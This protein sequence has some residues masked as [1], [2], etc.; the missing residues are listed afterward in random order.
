MS[1]SRSDL[2]D[3]AGLYGK[4]QAALDWREKLARLLAYKAVDIPLTDD[5]MNFHQQTRNG[6]GWK[7]LAVIGGLGLGYYGLTTRQPE[8][9]AVPVQPPAAT[10]PHED[11]DTT[12]GIGIRPYVPPE[13]KP[14]GN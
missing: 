10:A 14:T 12:R 2:P 6:W 5:G 8:P 3:K 13:P 9:P 4:F 11:R 7:E 1:D